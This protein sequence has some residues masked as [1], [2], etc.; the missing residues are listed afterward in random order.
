MEVIAL[1]GDDSIEAIKHKYKSIYGIV[2]HPERMKEPVLPNDVRS[3]L[4]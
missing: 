1:S 4:L 2:W 3:I